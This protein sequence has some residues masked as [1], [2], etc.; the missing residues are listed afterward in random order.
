MAITHQDV[1]VAL[2]GDEPVQAKRG[3]ATAQHPTAAVVGVELF[4]AGGNVVDVA[5]ATA[6]ANT[7]AD[8]GRTGVGGY[9]GHLVFH[10]ATAGETWLVDFSSRA[11]MKSHAQMFTPIKDARRKLDS[12]GWWPTEGNANQTGPLAVGVPAVVAGLAAAHGRFGKLAWADVLE[13]A[14]RLAED[15]IEFGTSG[16]D[17]V[18]D[19]RSRAAD[20]AETQSVFMDAWEGER[21]RQPDLARSLRRLAEH[22]AQDF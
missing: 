2:A 5:V 14:I 11:P 8:V 10:D 16:R 22:G 21:L 18:L 19:E 7:V 17:P 3:V 1:R 6:F 20:F 4:A 13:P 15:G 9:G 12:S